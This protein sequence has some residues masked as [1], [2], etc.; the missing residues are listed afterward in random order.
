MF[1]SYSDLTN[2]VFIIFNIVLYVHHSY[3]MYAAAQVISRA[4]EI[5][6]NI[7]QDRSFGPLWYRVTSRVAA[8]TSKTEFVVRERE[9][10]AKTEIRTRR[11]NIIQLSFSS[12]L[13][14]LA[15]ACG[16]WCLRNDKSD[17]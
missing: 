13:L 8:R 14:D 4:S 1:P 12:I 16:S 6:G 2:I 15:V 11:S 9:S 17:K 7:S 10:V 3:T 5:T